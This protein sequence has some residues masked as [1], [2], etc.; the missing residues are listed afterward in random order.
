MSDQISI[1]L[2]SP[3]RRILLL[4]TALLFLAAFILVFRWCLAD[5]AATRAGNIEIAEFT[6]QWA[7]DDPQTHYTVGLLYEKSFSPVL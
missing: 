2:T 7:P 1:S 6:A 4:L 3:A 5:S